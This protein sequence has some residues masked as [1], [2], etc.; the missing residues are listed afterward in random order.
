MAERVVWGGKPFEFPKL[1][2]GGVAG[3]SHTYECD[4]DGVP[5]EAQ[6]KK[7][8]NPRVSFKKER[9][10]LIGALATLGLVYAFDRRY[11]SHNEDSSSKV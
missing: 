2:T 8:L 1:G 3:A 4:T 5:T 6:V 11:C 10:F 7:W 9:P